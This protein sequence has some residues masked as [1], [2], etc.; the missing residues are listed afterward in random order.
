M[1]EFPNFIIIDPQFAIK[2]F[3]NVVKPGE[4]PDINDFVLLEEILT[5]ISNAF[6][7]Y[8]SFNN[9]LIELLAFF[10]NESHSYEGDKLNRHALYL[11]VTNLAHNIVKIL[12][13]NGFYMSGIFPYF[14]H[15]LNDDYSIGF[16]L[17][18]EYTSEMYITDTYKTT[19]N[20]TWLSYPVKI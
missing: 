11:A 3:F 20:S 8:P 18:E 10:I 19:D 15:K 12:A 16:K 17:A 5:S 9:T 4:K 6:I 7:D 14:F 1:K 2:E 13:N